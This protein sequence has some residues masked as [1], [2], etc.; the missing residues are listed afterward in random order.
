M[1]QS[2]FRD[3]KLNAEFLQLSF[4]GCQRNDE[5]N[6]ETLLA[7]EED[8]AVFAFIQWSLSAAPG[9]VM[10]FQFDDDFGSNGFAHGRDPW[11]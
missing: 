5:S 6:R 1:R 10:Q 7:D 3:K 2:R 8:T 9:R 11:V 4:A